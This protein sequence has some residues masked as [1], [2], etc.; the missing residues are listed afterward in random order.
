MA[1]F[2]SDLYVNTVAK[3][4]LQPGEQVLHRVSGSHAPW[5]SMGIPLFSSQDLVLATNQRLVLVR[6]KKGFL[7]GDRMESVDTLP[8]SQVSE[9]KLSGFFAKKTMR[10]KAQG[11]T[12]PVDLSLGVSGGFLEIPKN[13]DDGKAIAQRFGQMKALPS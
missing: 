8:W 5:W 13:V 10:L 12:G 11:S 1:L 6:H 2:F 9:V 4:L 7:T 3:G